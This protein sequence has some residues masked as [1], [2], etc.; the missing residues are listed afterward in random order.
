ME[1]PDGGASPSAAPGQARVVVGVVSGSHFVNHMFLVVLPPIL[2]LLVVD[3]QVTLA[4]LG[5]ALGTQGAVNVVSQLPFGYLSDNYSRVGTLGAGLTL[6]ALGTFAIAA[7][8]VIAWVF[9]GQ[10]LIGLGLAAHHPVHFPLLSDAVD[11]SRRARVFSI[12]GFAG[13]MG[14]AGTPA[15]ITLVLL[16]PGTTWRTAMWLIGGVALLYAVVSVA[17]L[18]TQ[19]ADEVLAPVPKEG[20]GEDGDDEPLLERAREEVRSILGSPAILALATLAFVIGLANWGVRS[21]AVVLLTDGY[22]LSV[23]LANVTYT[24]MFVFSAL[25]TILGGVLADR[26]SALRILLLGFVALF[27]TAVLAGSLLVPAV[28]AALVLIVTAGSIA[29]STPARSKVTDALSARED[30]GMNFALVTI[31]VASAGAIAPP[32]FGSIITYFDLTIA[33]YGVAALAVVA[34]VLTVLVLHHY[35]QSLGE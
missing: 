2:G 13:Q 8:P 31:G 24:A 34:A 10:A 33:F 7:A 12:H 9:L 25:A 5:L 15:I 4:T 6:L 27:V 18:R 16:V 20:R 14:A 23:N 3:F 17:V 21:Y 22:G 28:V 30:L 26:L 1:S 35:R 11:E 29:F 32:V 19:V